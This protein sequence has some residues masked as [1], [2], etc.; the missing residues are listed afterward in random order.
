MELKKK[1]QGLPMNVIVIGVI[2]LIVLLVLIYIV[3]SQ[4]GILNKGLMDC[5]SKGGSCISGD[6][7]TADVVSYNCDGDDEEGSD[8][9]CCLS[10]CLAKKGQCVNNED[11]SGESKEKSYFTECENQGK[12]C[13]V[14]SMT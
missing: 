11:C 5:K 4:T 14:T 10:R 2:S 9:V 12:V 6:A 7:C 13:C 1:A 8:V 3:V